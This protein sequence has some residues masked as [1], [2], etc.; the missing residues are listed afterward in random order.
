MSSVIVTTHPSES[1]RSD[2][3]EAHDAGLR[4]WCWGVAEVRALASGELSWRSIVRRD[5]YDP[6]YATARWYDGGE[7]VVTCSREAK[8]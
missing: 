2:L 4:T 6:D 3:A 1:L 5:G 8:S 7:P